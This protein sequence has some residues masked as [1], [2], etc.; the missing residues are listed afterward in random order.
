MSTGGG[1]V[2][3]EK[4]NKRRADAD[5]GSMTGVAVCL[6]AKGAVTGAAGEMTTCAVAQRAQPE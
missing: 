2:Y 3:R 1:R 5:C 6:A 4:S